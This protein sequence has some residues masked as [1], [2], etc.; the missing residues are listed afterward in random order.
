LKS[1]KSPG[2]DQIPTALIQAGGNAKYSDIHKLIN[3]IWNKEELPEQRKESIILPI[4][5]K[6]DRTDFSNYRGI[7]L[8]ST[9]YKILSN[10]LLPRFTPYVDELLATISVDFD[11]IHQ[12]LI[13]YFAFARYWRKNGNTMGLYISYL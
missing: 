8:F 12:L 3:F 7:S 5:K 1:Y 11:V 13:R 9:S 4:Y 10:I 2:S 6:G